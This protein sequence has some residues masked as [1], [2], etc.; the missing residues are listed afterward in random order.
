MSLPESV[1]SVLTNYANFTG[2]ARR[3][4][5]WWFTLAAF[6]VYVVL[7]SLGRA[8]SIFTV[9]YLLVALALLVPSLAVGVRRL[10]DTDKSGWFILL[11]LVPLVGGIVLLVFYATAGTDGPNRFGPSPKAAP[12]GAA[13]AYQ[14]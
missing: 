7:G 8:S 9:L 4:E 14:A 10:H 5:Y 1:R 12:V 2:R 6:V 3:S 11:A 13:P